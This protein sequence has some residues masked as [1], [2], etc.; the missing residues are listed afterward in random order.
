MR[1]LQR[2]RDLGW[3][4]VLL[5]APTVLVYLPYRRAQVE[6]GLRRTLENWVVTPESFIASPTHVHQ[7]LLQHVTSA[8]ILETAS[9]FLFPGVLPLVLGAVGLAWCARG[10]AVRRGSLM[11]FGVALAVG[12]VCGCRWGRLS[13]SGR[14]STTGPA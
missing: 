10:S 4:G 3:R 11:L 13:G 9:A 14:W 2:L 8:P 5:L 12:R 1:P 7:W 6:M